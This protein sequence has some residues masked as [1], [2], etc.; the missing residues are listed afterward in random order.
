MK[1]RCTCPFLPRA[2]RL[3]HSATKR[4][5]DAEGY[6]QDRWLRPSRHLEGTDV[7]AGPTRCLE[8]GLLRHLSQRQERHAA[9]RGVTSTVCV[10]RA[11]VTR[12]HRCEFFIKSV[13]ARTCRH[14]TRMIRFTTGQLA[15][16]ASATVDHVTCLLQ[17]S[18]LELL[19]RLSIT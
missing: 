8:H 17:D 13:Y 10:S 5:R 18:W 11:H 16:A 4:L 14:M 12:P 1:R 2:A 6:T 15:G 7:N 19:R 3:T 9:A